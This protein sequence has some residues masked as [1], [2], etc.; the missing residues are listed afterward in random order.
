MV[1]NCLPQLQKI[2]QTNETGNRRRKPPKQDDP[3]NTFGQIREEKLNIWT[4]A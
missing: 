4:E 3:L 2:L 1:Y